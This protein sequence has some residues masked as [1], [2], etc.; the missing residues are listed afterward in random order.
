MLAEERYKRITN[1]IHSD[2]TVTVQDLVEKLGISES[3]ARRDLNELDKMGQVEKVRGGAVA[4][5]SGTLSSR[6]DDVLLRQT[7]NIGEKS[8]VARYAASLIEPT[9]FVYLDAG[10]TTE[11]M[12]DFISAKTAVFVTNAIGHAKKLAA[13]GIKVYLL[14][15]EFKSVTEAIVGEDALYLIR[16]YN[17]TK[18][19][20]GTN[21]ITRH[22]GFTTPEVKEAMIKESALKHTKKP[23]ILADSSKFGRISS[24]CF[25]EYGD[26]L[27]LTDHVSKKE[28]Q[29]D[30]NIVEVLNL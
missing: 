28:F 27:I 21:G 8:L 11:C 4:I 16:K 2:G 18:G 3:T 25:A 26:A 7:R 24:V 5:D 29:N 23:Y 17:F 12:I 22:E 13:K 9:D 10:T 20:F 1:L 19:F 6:D 14:G 30:T 15:G